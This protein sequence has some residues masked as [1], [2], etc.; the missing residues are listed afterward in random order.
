M[1][2]NV[3]IK[4]PFKL[5]LIFLLLALFITGCPEDKMAKSDDNEQ[6]TN[7]SAENQQISQNNAASEKAVFAAGCFWGVQAAFDDVNGVKSTAAGYTGGHTINPT[8]AQVC[9]DKTGHAEAILIEYDPNQ[10]TYQKLLDTFFSIHDLTTLNRQGPDVGSQYRS[11]I[12]YLNEKQKIAARTTVENLQKSGKFK[13]PIVTEITPASAFYPAEQYHQRY[14]FKRGLATCHLPMANTDSVYV[15]PTE[16]QL[17][18]KLTPLQ[19]EVTQNKATEVPF[20]GKFDKFFQ[21]GTYKCIV[22]GNELFTSE[23]KFD[24]GCGW[25]AFYEAASDNNIKT[26]RD[27]SYGMVRTEVVCSKC[28]A[29]LGH[30]FN[31]A[32]QTP[33]GL[34]YCIN[35]TSL[36]FEKQKAEQKAEPNS[37]GAH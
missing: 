15:K 5:P 19:Y 20:T 7:K 28:G 3:K 22:C 30:L 14:L 36:D 18:E 8:Y 37:P 16:K 12:F 6:K 31:D 24:S 1:M 9:T 33:T 10:V 32:P 21:G 27:T 2:H 4:N 13:N 34:R 25:P 11:A 23:L 17:R 35:S 26:E 29:H